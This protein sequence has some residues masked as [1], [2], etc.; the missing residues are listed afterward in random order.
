MRLIA[1]LVL[2]V[3][4]LLGIALV[5]IWAPLPRPFPPALSSARNL[6]AAVTVGVLGLGVLAGV[7]ALAVGQASGAGRRLGQSLAAIGLVRV[8][9]LPLSRAYVGTLQ[10]RS[11]RAGWVP[12]YGV[13]PGQFLA[14][15]EA[16]VGLTAAVGNARPL[17]PTS[18]AVRIDLPARHDWTP[19]VW[20]EADQA[21][22][23]TGLLR[24][25]PV[26]QALTALLSPAVPGGTRDLEIAHDHI[27]FR[28][29]PDGVTLGRCAAS[30]V[31]T[32]V[33][34]AGYLARPAAPGTSGGIGQRSDVET[35]NTR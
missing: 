27:T 17:R 29:R 5:L 23:L 19:V 28:A 24:D 7:A 18:G 2:S 13:R 12:G 31:E 22:R 30:W 33:D 32:L 26:A 11:V 9:S 1:L 21:S 34:L 3:L 4:L 25:P 16:D 10:G 15:V 14:T 8:R 35:A 20:V 6:M